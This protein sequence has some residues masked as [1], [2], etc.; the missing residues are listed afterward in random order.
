MCVVWPCVDGEIF[1]SQ[2]Y[3]VTNVLVGRCIDVSL[4]TVASLCKAMQPQA[5]AARLV[6][7]RC[8]SGVGNRRREYHT[9][10]SL[11]LHDRRLEATLF[12]YSARIKFEIE[13]GQ[14]RVG[15]NPIRSSG[16]VAN[17]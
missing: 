15:T 17:I 11:Q 9:L 7:L 1:I 2:T 13:M 6:Q 5:A 12:L 16:Q 4:Y 14:L 10:Y 8:R 3:S